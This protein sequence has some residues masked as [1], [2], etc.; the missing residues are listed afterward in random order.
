MCQDHDEWVIVLQGEAGLRI[1]DSAAAVLKPGDHIL[2]ER[3]KR[4][5]VTHTATDEPTV[6]LVVHL[7]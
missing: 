6:W 3:G 2:I 1:E 7:G 4:H 5:W